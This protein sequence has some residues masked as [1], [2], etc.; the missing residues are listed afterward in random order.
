MDKCI[1][2]ETFCV[3]AIYF[4]YLEVFGILK[5]FADGSRSDYRG[6]TL[7]E[8]SQWGMCNICRCYGNTKE[9]TLLM[10]RHSILISGKL[11]LNEKY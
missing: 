2:S 7:A 11:N 5:T 9:S 8:Q 4:K 10:R 6:I 1:I 3:Q